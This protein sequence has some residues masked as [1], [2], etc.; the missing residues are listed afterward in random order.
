MSRL[1]GASAGYVGYEVGGQ[2]TEAA[3]RRPY[4]V[5]L[6]DEFE[7]AHYDVSNILL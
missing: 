1:I 2:L 7:K 6:F 5:I 3:R 4:Q